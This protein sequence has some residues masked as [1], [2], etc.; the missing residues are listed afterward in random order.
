MRRFET[1]D[2]VFTTWFSKW[3]ANTYRRT[4]PFREK[5][6]ACC[7]GSTGGAP[8]LV[9][10]HLL[11][12]LTGECCDA[13]FEW[14]GSQLTVD[15]PEESLLFVSTDEDESARW[16][17]YHNALGITFRDA[18]FGLL[19]EYCTWVEQKWCSADDSSKTIQSALNESMLSSYLDTI[20]A[21]GWKPGRFTIGEGWCPRTGEGGYGD[22]TPRSD[23][24]LAA[25]AAK[26][27]SAGHIPGLWMSPVM[28]TKDSKAALENP[29]LVGTPV[30]MEGECDWNRCFYI[31]PSDASQDLINNLFGRAFDWGFRKFKLD[32][33]YGP[34][35]DMRKI[36]EQCRIA[37]DALPEKVELE[38]HIPDPFCAQYMDVIRINDLLVSAQHSGWRD[39][40]NGHLYV[41]RNSTP[42]MVL[43][44]DHIGGNFTDVDEKNFIEHLDL[45]KTHFDVGYPCLSLL[46]QHVGPAAERAVTEVLSL[47]PVGRVQ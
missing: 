15:I 21:A 23:L 32:L 6:C 7:A 9:S 19:P 39:V 27:K 33:F 30:Q 8:V 10:D 16:A 2:T 41:C 35:P 37:A 18:P 25:L 34:K 42:G 3:N 5:P 1:S 47:T 26:I 11:V 43:N 46:P 14:D 28:I 40:C 17:Q 45:L 31:P 4:A 20:Q 12:G 38:G 13:V 22:W 29:D 44:L 36:L 24:D